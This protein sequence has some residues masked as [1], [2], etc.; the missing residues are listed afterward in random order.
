[1]E[2][3]LSLKIL[4]QRLS[5]KYFPIDW[6][7]P[8]L[9][10]GLS[11]DENKALLINNVSK[12]ATNIFDFL[13]LFL[14]SGEYCK[15]TLPD[16]ERESKS[17]LDFLELQMLEIDALSAVQDEFVYE[18]QEFFL[19][20]VKNPFEKWVNPLMYYLFKDL[21]SQLSFRKDYTK[22][23]FEKKIKPKYDESVVPYALTFR[24]AVVLTNLEHFKYCFTKDL[25][26]ELLLH[27]KELEDIV[28]VNTSASAL[29]CKID[30]L[31][32]KL[33]YR[34]ESQI[35]NQAVS[36]SYDHNQE[37]IL[38]SQ[39]TKLDVALENWDRIIRV[40]Y[41][42]TSNFKEDQRKRAKAFF[43]TPRTNYQYFHALMKI[44][45][46]DT[47]SLEQIKN[48]RI[49][50]ESFEHPKEFDFDKYSEVVTGNYLFNSEISL[51][52]EEASVTDQDCSDRFKDFLWEIKNF[53]NKE[54]YHN[55][56]PWK[57]LCKALAEKIEQISGDLLDENKFDLFRSLTD[58][59]AHSLA[60]FEE[61]F[62]WSRQKNLLPFQLTFDDCK[63]DYVIASEDFGSFKLFFFSSFVI[64]IDF[65][66]ERK[67]LVSLQ[68]KKMKFET[69]S[70]TYEKLRAVVEEVNDT[71]TRLRNSERR[72]IEVLA[73]FSA[74]SLFSVGSIQLL[75]NPSV[76]TDPTLF[77]KIVMSFGYC[78]IL[79]VVVI[80]I[81]TRDNIKH[82]HWVHWV[83]IIILLVTSG[84][85][86]NAFLSTS[87]NELLNV[88]DKAQTR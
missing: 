33:A 17:F 59:L 11:I 82:V 28:G 81:I 10:P 73:I 64:P 67:T 87:L 19:N 6:I 49:E 8:H 66:T 71:S 43:G 60:K 44:Y 88:R 22:F 42:F 3:E 58:V 70:N 80:W 61:A 15:V 23:R 68:Q 75:T 56:F 79:F 85:V 69:L 7:K 34:T 77:Y 46:D 1:M 16:W 50:F 5:D 27:K 51:R 54:I 83:L 63:S 62:E 4:Q 45:K 40:H 14:L 20:N 52:I 18:A 35:K 47:R 84:I 36:Y 65:A 76:S 78:L 48:L 29:I 12:A 53:Q 31:M 37:Y 74:I 25:L 86:I 21:E 30:F 41:G 57:K 26:G 13:V 2:G 32:K 9:V 38:S 55:Y 39:T 72:S 24:I